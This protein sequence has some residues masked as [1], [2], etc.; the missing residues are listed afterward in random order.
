MA[1]SDWSEKTRMIVTIAVGVVVNAA[2]GYFLY[3]AYA[4][5]AEVVRQIGL[6]QKE[7]KALADKLEG[8]PQRTLTKLEEQK[9]QFAEKKNRLPENDPA[10]AL[11]AD[12][13]KVAVEAGA[14]LKS[15]LKVASAGDVAPGTN[16]EKATLKTVW[17]AD[18]MQFCDVLNKMEDN[19]GFDRFVSFENLT[20]TPKNQGLVPST[21]MH[22]IN[23]DIITYRYVSGP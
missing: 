17:D 7:R 1:A 14:R 21:T 15:K 6:K 23:V 9:K 2:L 10:E 4:Q 8:E 13:P 11:L 5:H 20:I 12:I 16:Y 3:S 19:I 22:V 18:L